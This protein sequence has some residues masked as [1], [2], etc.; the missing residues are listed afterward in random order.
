MR[1]NSLA[2][3]QSD[4]HQTLRSYPGNEN[5]AMRSINKGEIHGIEH[6][7]STGVIYVTDRAIKNG[8]TSDGGGWANFGQGAPEGIYHRNL[9]FF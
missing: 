4:A 5:R 7:G 9:S 8:Y 3:H 1:L 2:E 6:P